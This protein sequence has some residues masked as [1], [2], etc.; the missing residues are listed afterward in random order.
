M[1]NNMK[2]INT[3]WLLLFNFCNSHFFYFSNYIQHSH[4]VSPITLLLFLPYFFISLPLK[5]NTPEVCR[6]DIIQLPLAFILVC[7]FF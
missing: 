2:E 7:Y 5:V 1:P 4:F 3:E 6:R